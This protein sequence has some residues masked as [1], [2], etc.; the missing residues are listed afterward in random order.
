MRLLFGLIAVSLITV[1]FATPASANQIL[2][3]TMRSMARDLDQVKVPSSKPDPAEVT[4]AMILTAITRARTLA[5]QLGLIR[6]RKEGEM[7]PDV[8]KPLTG[9][10]LEEKLKVYAGLLDK[11]IGFVNAAEVKLRE[12]LEQ[13]AP[14]DFSGV[15][16]ELTKVDQTIGEAHGVFKPKP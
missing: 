14:R 8:T 5:F 3:Y 9:A 12:S 10:E 11:A 4:D 1:S 15:K 13:P 16:A 2:A 7:K 6:D